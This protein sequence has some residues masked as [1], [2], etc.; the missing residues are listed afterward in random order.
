MS[1]IDGTVPKARNA[2]ELSLI[3]HIYQR[4]PSFC[5]IQKNEGLGLS[6]LFNITTA[7]SGMDLLRIKESSS[8]PRTVLEQR[9]EN[10]WAPLME[11]KYLTNYSCRN[12]TFRGC[13]RDEMLKGSPKRIP[14]GADGRSVE[15]ILPRWWMRTGQIRDRMH[16]LGIKG[17]WMLGFCD[18]TNSEHQRTA[19]CSFM[20]AT[21][22]AP[23]KH[24][25][26]KLFN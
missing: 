5:V 7:N 17:P 4:V 9:L 25:H 2:R 3:A 12:S 11:G 14:C 23:T 15:P 19:I 20:P 16:Q 13:T 8:D 10:D 21:A 6:T 24:R 22:A 1:P 18:V 26:D